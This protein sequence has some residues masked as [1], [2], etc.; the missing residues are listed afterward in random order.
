MSPSAIMNGFHSKLGKNRALIQSKIDDISIQDWP[1]KTGAYA[2]S[3]VY[4]A[5]TPLP[6]GSALLR[7]RAAGICGSDVKHNFG[8]GCKL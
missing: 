1:L 7:V 4:E 3:P 5:G 2:D 6:R 8:S